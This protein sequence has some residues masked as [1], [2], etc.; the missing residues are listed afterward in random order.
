MCVGVCVCVCV[1]VR[2][3]VCGKRWGGGG[4]AAAAWGIRRSWLNP[5]GFRHD[6]AP[7]AVMV[8]VVGALSAFYHGTADVS[9]PEER[10][11]AA[12]RI[13][14]KMPTLAA[15]AYKHSVGASPAA[16]ALPHSL[17][18]KRAACRRRVVGSGPSRV[19]SCTRVRMASS[20]SA[21]PS[22]TRRCTS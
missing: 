7:M 22:G 21:A 1:C 20:T 16:F 19:Q 17:E 5:Q 12:I 3:C 8:G 10:D 6:A 4:G 2:V 9:D 14:A 15:I 18:A 11:L 13:I